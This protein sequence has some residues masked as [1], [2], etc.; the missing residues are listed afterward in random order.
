MKT[1][2][3]KKLLK[4]PKKH[5]SEIPN[6]LLVESD[7][8]EAELYTDLIN[9]TVECSIDV[10]SHFGENTE[11]GSYSPYQLVIIDLC[12]NKA[13]DDKIDPISIL[14]KIKRTNPETGI[15]FI[16]E[17][18]T[19]E[20]AVASIRFGAE[21]FFKKPFNFES[22]K[23]AVK[24]GLDRK[25]VFS[26]NAGAEE[27]FNLLNS[28]QL[29]SA[30]M[31]QIKIFKIIK[32]YFSKE[33]SMKY[34]AFYV[35]ENEEYERLEVKGFEGEDDDAIEEV[36]DIAIAASNPF[37]KLKTSKEIFRFVD[38]GKLTPGFFVFH[39]RCAEKKDFFFVGLS[40]KKPESLDAF[41]NRVR[42]LRRQI[43]VTGKN[44]NQYEGVQNLVYLDDATGLY[45]TR[46]LNYIL[47]RE[48]Q[49]SQLSR[50]SFAVLFIDADHFK[51]VND[52]HGHLVGTKLLNELGAHLKRLL[53]ERDSVFRYGGDE[54]IAV[55][56]PS[57]LKTALSVAERIRASVEARDFLKSEN[58]D[59]KFTV[60]IGVA[61]YPD[62]A[63][64]KKSVIELADRAM[65]QAKKASRNSVSVISEPEKGKES[66]EK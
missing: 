51:S 56:S 18:V 65:Y 46:Y 57:D 30:S 12:S 10:L 21:D 17:Y 60:S 32:S 36:L 61:L 16:S 27:Y 19:V 9:E 3:T 26:G 45:N 4:S 39:F 42:L 52:Q 37:P 5:S 41:E 13:I 49:N 53:R 2:K 50:Q 43:E 64:S 40:P 55:L 14:E 33:L 34:S 25:V 59:V 11:W 29:I 38:R 48:I 31:E 63:N 47:D 54:F 58:V 7:S 35:S 6:I 8:K 1:L 22:F 24:R 66:T 28:C 15:I 44:I 62:H 23:L 20:Q